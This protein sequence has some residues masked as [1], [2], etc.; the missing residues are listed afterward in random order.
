VH[1]V[2]VPGRVVRDD[3]GAGRSKG[4]RFFTWPVN[5]SFSASSHHPFGQVQLTM[6]RPM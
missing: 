3:Q 4:S 5:A 6:L 1:H 2:T